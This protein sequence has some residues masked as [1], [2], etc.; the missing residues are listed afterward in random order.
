MRIQGV[1]APIPGVPC[2]ISRVPRF[3]QSG[4]ERE[5]SGIDY[6][7]DVLMPKS[8]ELSSFGYRE[9]DNCPAMIAG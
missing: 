6:E 3:R 2:C 7:L 4:T 8:P 9:N 1:P 5:L